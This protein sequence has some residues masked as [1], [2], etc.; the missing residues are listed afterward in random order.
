LKQQINMLQMQYQQALNNNMNSMNNM[1]NMTSMNSVSMPAPTMNTFKPPPPP[2]MPSYTPP[3]QSN[4]ANQ[5][6][7]RHQYSD[8][9]TSFQ[10]KSNNPM[11]FS[12]SSSTATTAAS[13][14]GAPR[15]LS[16]ALGGDYSDGYSQPQRPT[17]SH[18][19]YGQP[20]N[21][22]GS[23][24]SGPQS[25]GNAAGGS[26]GNAINRKTGAGG[27]SLAS[28]LGSGGGA[29]GGGGG[30]GGFSGGGAAK[31]GNRSTPFATEH[32]AVDLMSQWESMERDLT[33]KMTEKN[34]LQDE[35]EK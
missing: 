5:Y 12:G 3:I 33:S 27:T 24:S 21:S 17:S 29:P 30:G 14:R 2:S 4:S 9:S 34:S 18:S 23:S 7:D 16:S 8:H 28:L 6:S 15:S 32:T 25:L 26:L 31:S 20:S 35:A 22:V 13:G 1:N 10:A 19:N 11:P